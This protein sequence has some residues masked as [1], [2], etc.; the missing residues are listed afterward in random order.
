MK[1]KK[2][3]K[4]PLTFLYYCEELDHLDIYA[5]SY[6]KIHKRLD[7]YLS[8]SENITFIYEYIG[9]FEEENYEIT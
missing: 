4:V 7:G 8:E 9:V 5:F 1:K 3:I 6:D 2:F